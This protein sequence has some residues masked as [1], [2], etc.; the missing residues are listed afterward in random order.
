MLRRFITDGTI[1]RVAYAA[2]VK[3]SILRPVSSR[4]RQG[5]PWRVS[6]I[7]GNARPGGLMQSGWF[8]FYDRRRIQRNGE[9]NGDKP[10][11]NRKRPAN[12]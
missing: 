9:T 11:G 4:F 1:V 6:R 5:H 10:R 7:R 12:I 2:P 8:D 3:S